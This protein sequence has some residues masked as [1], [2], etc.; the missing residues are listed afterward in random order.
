M[1]EKLWEKIEI[2]VDSV[3]SAI[4]ADR[5]GASRVELCR[6]CSREITPSIA[7][8]E[9]IRETT[10]IPIHVLY[11][12]VLEIFIFRGGIYVLCKETGVFQKQL[13]ALVGCVT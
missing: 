4:A 9:R 7:L 3:E 2:C 10:D 5:G 13:D 11:V 8:F 6:T 12:H 1:E